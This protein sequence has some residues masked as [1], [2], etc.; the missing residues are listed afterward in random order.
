MQCCW[1]GLERQEFG[2]LLFT[3]TIYGWNADL[4]ILQCLYT[5][6]GL[7]KQEL[8]AQWL[9]RQDMHKLMNCA[10]SSVYGLVWCP[11]CY[12]VTR[13]RFDLPRCGIEH[14]QKYYSVLYPATQKT[15]FYFRIKI[16]R[17]IKKEIKILRGYHSVA[18]CRRIFMKN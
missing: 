8:C 17:Q 5:W 18:P 1:F 16:S 2:A 11:P 10:F 3:K 4:L 7:G 6:F 12:S 13:F 15:F 14:G 9:Q